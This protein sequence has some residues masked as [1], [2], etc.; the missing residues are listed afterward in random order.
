M[1]TLQQE[2]F[3]W[4]G[5][6]LVGVDG[7]PLEVCGQTKISLTLMKR[8]FQVEVLIVDSLTTEAILGVNFLEQNNILINLGSKQLLFKGDN[9]SISMQ[10][11]ND[12][13]S[14]GYPS[15]RVV[16]TVRIPPH[17]ELMIIAEMVNSMDRVS[18]LAET[19]GGTRPSALVARALVKPKE[20]E[21]LTKLLNPRDTPTIIKAGIEV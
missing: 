16:E 17:S 3:E 14:K 7:T 19:N 8:C 2:L 21:V 15:I 18:Y 10:G 12:S 6:S 4:T 9:S 11:F 1:N 20:N 5:P 13:E